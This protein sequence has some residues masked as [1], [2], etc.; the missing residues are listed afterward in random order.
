MICAYWMLSWLLAL[1]WLVAS[2]GAEG[3]SAQ[4]RTAQ[5]QRSKFKVTG[6][7]CALG[8]VL[9][10]LPTHS[11]TSRPEQDER[12]FT[13]SIFKCIFLNEDVWILFKISLKFVLESSIDNKSSLVQVM[14]WCQ[15]GAKPLPDPMMA[16][17]N[18]I[19]VAKPQCVSLFLHE[20]CLLY[21]VVLGP[22][23]FSWIKSNPSMDK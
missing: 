22:L 9:C 8:R 1:M 2:E 4:R 19:C 11:N 6:C 18:N 12:Y 17:F 5:G 23:V 13:D 3:R 16:Q 21:S 10:A 15:A 20:F 14:A 7:C